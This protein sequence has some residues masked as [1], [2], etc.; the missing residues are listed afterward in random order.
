MDSM[1]SLGY[2]GEFHYSSLD[3]RKNCLLLILIGLGHTIPPPIFI[4]L[5]ATGIFI[6]CQASS[7]HFRSGIKLTCSSLDCLRLF[8]SSFSF[9]VEMSY[10]FSLLE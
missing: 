6:A 8:F 7:P 2:T 3:P 5:I 9:Q 1:I 4:L 10:L